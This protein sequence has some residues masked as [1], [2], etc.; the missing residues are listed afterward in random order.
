MGLYPINK[1]T[2][3]CIKPGG[4]WNPMK[5]ISFVQANDYFASMIEHVLYRKK[6][7]VTMEVQSFYK[8]I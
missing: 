7:P 1:K 3:V 4:D 2:A 5:N 8:K 6:R